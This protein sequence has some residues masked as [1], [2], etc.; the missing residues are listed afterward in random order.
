MDLTPFDLHCHQNGWH[1]FP[2]QWFSRLKFLHFKVEIYMYTDKRHKIN[3]KGKFKRMLIVFS[4]GRGL[5]W[6]PA[7][8]SEIEAHKKP[9]KCSPI[10]AQRHA[11]SQTDFRAST[12]L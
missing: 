10:W 12:E 11:T 4:P 8:K 1:G 5:C 3:G 7:R 6:I 2:M 9:R